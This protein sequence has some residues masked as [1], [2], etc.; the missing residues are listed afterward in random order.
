[1]DVIRSPWLTISVQARVHR[2]RRINKKWA[3]R[4]GFKQVPDPRVYV[5]MGAI[6]GHPVTIDKMLRK[7]AWKGEKK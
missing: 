3:K 2:R 6:M 5:L 7:I 1:M 4:Y